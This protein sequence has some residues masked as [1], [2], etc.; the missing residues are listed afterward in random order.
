M[1]PNVSTVSV[2]ST[3]SSQFF[4]FL[5]ASFVGM[6]FKLEDFEVKQPTG[7]LTENPAEDKDE[8]TDVEMNEIQFGSDNDDEDQNNLEK[9][10][11]NT[12][13]EN[14]EESNTISSITKDSKHLLNLAKANR[15]LSFLTS[16]E[17][18]IATYKEK[19]Q[20]RIKKTYLKNTKLKK[21]DE[22][23]NKTIKE[24]IKKVDKKNKKRNLKSSDTAYNECGDI[25]SDFAA[26]GVSRIILK[27][28]R[29]ELKWNHPTPDQRD[30]IP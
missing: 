29:K 4:S 5:L 22:K 8:E 25:S 16:I 12:K 28:I 30:T 19:Y 1:I 6:A 27:G 15:D 20:N 14:A 9:A 13:S 2:R 26:L 10:E 7:L 21:E 17:D 23:W 3:V 11:E 18:K 24:S